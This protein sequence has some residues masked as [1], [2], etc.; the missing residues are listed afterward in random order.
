MRA[1]SRVN[2]RASMI[3]SVTPFIPAPMSKA[4]ALRCSA[5]R[6]GD[7]VAESLVGSRVDDRLLCLGMS[8]QDQS[9]PRPFRDLQIADQEGRSRVGQGESPTR[10]R[11]SRSAI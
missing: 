10:L 9:E 11:P 6:R 3:V 1:L 4:R 8:D 5:L 2:P 7:I